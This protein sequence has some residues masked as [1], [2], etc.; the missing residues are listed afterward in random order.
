MAKRPNFKRALARAI[1]PTGGP[2]AILGTLEDAERF[3]GLMQPWR[4]ARPYWDFAAELVLRA[5]QSG[6]KTDIE[7]ATTQI[8]CALWADGWL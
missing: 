5:A 8:E 6:R 3:M 2:G 1:E 7:A 4:Q